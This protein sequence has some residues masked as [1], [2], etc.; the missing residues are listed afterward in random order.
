MISTWAATSAIKTTTKDKEEHENEVQNSLA[1]GNLT[2]EKDLKIA[3]F[4]MCHDHDYQD[5]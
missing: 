1:V 2:E 5:I 4:W 3:T